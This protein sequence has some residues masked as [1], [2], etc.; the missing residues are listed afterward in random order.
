MNRETIR[1]N[2][3]IKNSQLVVF[4]TDTVYSLSCLNGADGAKK[5]LRVKKRSVSKKF[6]VV[7]GRHDVQRIKHARLSAA[8][9]S[10]FF[11]G[12]LTLVA[13]GQSV[14]CI[15]VPRLFVGDAKNRLITTSLNV[16][17]ET[18]C[19]TA[20]QVK[21]FI[22]KH[23]QQKIFFFENIRLDPTFNFKIYR[24]HFGLENFD[25]SQFCVALDFLRKNNDVGP[26]LVVD[27]R[28]NAV[29]RQNVLIYDF[30]KKFECNN[31]V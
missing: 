23:N 16:S 25:F 13:D 30:L 9:L 4:P 15:N 27:T 18:H 24:K 7:F 3:N 21:K 20:V 5:I 8:K 19:V 28:N 11:A 22:A 6:I 1:L 12:Y 31:M 29:I 17:G 2:R 14:K 10:L 26:S